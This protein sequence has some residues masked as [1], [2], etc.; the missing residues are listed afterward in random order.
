MKVKIRI[1]R[2]TNDL[3]RISKMYSEG[4]SLKI[5]GSF[6]DHANFDGVML[7]ADEVDYHFEFTQ[8]RGKKAPH[9]NSPEQ[10]NVFYT[11]EI[12]QTEILKRQMQAAGFRIVK[13]HNPYWDQH[14]CTFEDFEEFRI[15]LCHR[16]WAP[17]G[18]FP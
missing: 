1:A 16:N 10:L 4:L 3:D 12:E 7:G 6:R 2:A 17:A 15:V 11:E 14:G 5:L 18:S 8:E 9:S 13:S